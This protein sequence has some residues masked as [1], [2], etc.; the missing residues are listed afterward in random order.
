VIVVPSPGRH[1]LH[2][3]FQIRLSQAHF[4]TSSERFATSRQQNITV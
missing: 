2:D 1:G 4:L 3:E